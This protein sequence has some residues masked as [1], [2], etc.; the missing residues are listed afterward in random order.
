MNTDSLAAYTNIEMNMNGEETYKSK[1]SREFADKLSKNPDSFFE[2]DVLHT[3][4]AYG[5]W[6]PG[7]ENYL[8]KI[9]KQKRKL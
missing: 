6:V 8:Y 2:L 3:G 5:S 1:Y 7:V 4:R 9:E